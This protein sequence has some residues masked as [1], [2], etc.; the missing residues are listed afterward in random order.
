WVVHQASSLVSAARTAVDGY[1]L[2]EVTFELGFTSSGHIAFV[3]SAEIATSISGTFK[4]KSHGEGAGGDEA[5]AT[6]GFNGD[7]G[8]AHRKAARPPR[9]SSDP[10]SGR[11]AGRRVLA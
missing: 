9:R 11:A 6:G 3:A 8:V 10:S 2:D 7:R 5:S 1:D 4:R